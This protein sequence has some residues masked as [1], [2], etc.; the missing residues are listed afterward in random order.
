MD[1]PILDTNDTADGKYGADESSYERKQAGPGHVSLVHDQDGN[2]VIAY[3]ARPYPEIHSG[4]AAGGLFDQDRNTWVKAVNV[5]ANGMIDASLTK[6]QEVTPTNRTV[7]VKVTVAETPKPETV[8]VTGVTLD[9]T[10]LELI[11]GDSATLTATVAPE[12]ATNKNVTW[13]SSDTLVATVDA[14]GRVVAVKAGSAVITVITKDGGFTATA[15][16]TVKDKDSGEPVNPGPG[17][18]TKP[19]SP[20]TPDGSDDQGNGSDADADKSGDADKSDD[21]DGKHLLSKTGVS[22]WSMALAALVLA[23]VGT[24][25]AAK[26]RMDKEA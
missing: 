8:P 17:E 7:T 26:R 13:T 25:F 3:H 16:V 5:R 15:K 11:A 12:K 24:G 1:F 23:G 2:M 10:S 18:T 14:S 6:D 9:K 21:A 22:V 20:T 4:S 19:T